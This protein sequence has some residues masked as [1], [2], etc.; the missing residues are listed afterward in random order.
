MTLGSEIS[1]R[2]ILL[3]GGGG[4]TDVSLFLIDTAIPGTDEAAR[5][6]ARK[7][8]VVARFTG[9]PGVP[10]LEHL[11]PLWRHRPLPVAGLTFGGAL[12]C[13]ERLARGFGLSCGFRSS[14]PP[15]RLAG[16]G[17]GKEHRQPAFGMAEAAFRAATDLAAYG[18]TRMTAAGI[19]APDRPLTWVLRP[20]H[21][22]RPRT[23]NGR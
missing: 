17:H 21:V 2:Q 11:E 22:R 7:G 18:Q 19:D 1:R 13:F 20:A 9:D 12:F 23:D 4:I 16:S 14:L 6:A 10:W 5:L 3:G 8:A 15:A